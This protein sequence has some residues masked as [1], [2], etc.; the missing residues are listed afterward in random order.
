MRVAVEVCATTLEEAA[1][2]IAAGVDTIELCVSLEDGGITPSHGLIRSALRVCGDRLRVLVRPRPGSFAY[3]RKE[4]DLMMEEV[5]H[6]YNLGCRRVVTGALDHRSAM[7][8]NAV[9][10]MILAVGGMEW[11]FHRGFDQL[12]DQ[13]K[14]IELCRGLGF[15]RILT[16]GGGETA[17]SGMER[18]RNLVR[19]SNGAIQIAAGGGIGPTNVVRLVE[20]SGVPEVHFSARYPVTREFAA[21]TAPAGSFGMDWLPDA[22]K[23]E[24]VLEALTKA[25]LR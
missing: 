18:I 15:S 8:V 3:S 19:R 13:A 22:R 14:G 6:A 24:G 9:H 25:G 16:S 7:D 20:S 10:E 21:E 17:I 11:T 12:A 23:I 4:L 5:S 2:A 1:T